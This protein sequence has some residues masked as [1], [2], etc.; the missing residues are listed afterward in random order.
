[1]IYPKHFRRRL[2]PSQTSSLSAAADL[3]PSVVVQ[4][5]GGV[6]VGWGGGGGGGVYVIFA[7]IL[8]SHYPSDARTTDQHRNQ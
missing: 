4:L 7:E 5:R 8:I 1:M 2:P 6:G 3:S